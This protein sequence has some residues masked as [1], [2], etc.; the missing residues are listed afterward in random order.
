MKLKVEWSVEWYV[1]IGILSLMHWLYIAGMVVW[2]FG[3]RLMS[4]L[5]TIFMVMGL[6]RV[7]RSA[8]ATCLFSICSDGK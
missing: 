4:T 1:F 6:P 2:E 5:S 8:M 3:G 7:D